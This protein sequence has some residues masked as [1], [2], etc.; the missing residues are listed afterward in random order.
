MGDVKLFKKAGDGAGRHWRRKGRT[1][2]TA[3]NGQADYATFTAIPAV[4]NFTVSS[5]HPVYGYAAQSGKLGFDGDVQ[6][7]TL[8]LNKLSSLRGVV[9]AIDGK[10]P[11]SGAAGHI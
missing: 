8:Q 7:I 6:S 5:Q 3:V 4:Q 10:T 2:S 9:Y 11:V 1:V